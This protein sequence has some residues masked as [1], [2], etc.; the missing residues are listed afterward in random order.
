MTVWYLPF[1]SLATQK[2]NTSL[3]KI[4]GVICGANLFCWMPIKTWIMATA[5]RLR[6]TTAGQSSYKGK[7]ALEI[8]L[9]GT[10]QRAYIPVSGLNSPDY[11]KWDAKN[12]QFIGRDENTA[13]NNLVAQTLYKSVE[14][15]NLPQLG[16]NSAQELKQAYL[17]G[18]KVQAK[19]DIAFGELVCKIADNEYEHGIGANYQAYRNLRNKLYSSDAPKLDGIRIADVPVIDICNKHYIAFFNW[20]Q[21]VH[22]EY[23]CK[24]LMA[25]FHSAFCRASNNYDI[26]TKHTLSFR[27][28]SKIR[29]KKRNNN[30]LVY[31]Y[32][33]KVTTISEEEIQRLANFDLSLIAPKQR[34]FKRLLEI[35]CDICL[36]MYYTLSRP[37][38]VIRMKWI[39]NYT[40]DTKTLIY[41][42]YKLRY[43]KRQ[44]IVKIGL[45]KKAVEIIEKYKG[46]NKHGYIFPLPINETDWDSLTN[47]INTGR[48]YQLKW[49]AKRN[50]T[51]GAINKYLKKI[52][53]VERFNVP[54]LNLYVLRHSAITHAIRQ[55]NM[56]TQIVADIAGTSVDKIMKHYL[57]N[58][59]ETI[60]SP[61]GA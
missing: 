41:G 33:N 60:M 30:N 46:Q 58:A 54:K 17:H 31:E 35:Y 27:W 25:L 26:Q 16:C 42:V 40:E 45:P 13:F 18:I 21:N 59:K 34:E 14:A 53:E 48:E 7:L 24:N 10:Q 36:F 5:F 57:G 47:W 43:K 8:S 51:I 22:P 55:H 44:H 19:K 11:S 6:L 39:K 49:D 38:D 12:A 50:H 56:N 29:D 28:R 32:D 9:K 20:L 23:N 1:V 15:I 2:N 3:H 37:A 52:Q 61:L 4:C